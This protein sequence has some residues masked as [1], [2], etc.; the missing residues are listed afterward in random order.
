[1]GYLYPNIK[2]CCSCAMGPTI[3]RMCSKLNCDDIDDV[4]GKF[5][6]ANDIPFHVSHFPYYKEMVKAIAT[7]GHSYVLNLWLY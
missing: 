6:F 5:L 7:V 3:A 1:M 2:G 4:I